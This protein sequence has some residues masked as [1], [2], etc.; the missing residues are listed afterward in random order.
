MI[1]WKENKSYTRYFWVEKSC[2]FDKDFWKAQQKV[3]CL[4]VFDSLK[5]RIQTQTRWSNYTKADKQLQERAKGKVF[6]I[7]VLG[8]W[9]KFDVDRWVGFSSQAVRSEAMVGRRLYLHYRFF[10]V[11]F[12][13]FFFAEPP[14]FSWL[15][16]EISNLRFLLPSGL[17]NF[18]IS[19]TTP[20]SFIVLTSLQ[21]ILFRYVDPFCG[22]GI[23][24][25]KISDFIKFTKLC[26]VNNVLKEVLFGFYTIV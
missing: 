24:K 13:Y 9:T 20:V 15:S 1:C 17:K 4:F 2:V 19:W 7:R 26:T 6:R 16:W 14:W 23:Y 25:I 8:N 10:L 22:P 5:T 3:R 21:D 11:R 18:L 12:L